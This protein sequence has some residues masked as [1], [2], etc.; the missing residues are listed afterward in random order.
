MIFLLN[1]EDNPT[2]SNQIR[3]LSTPASPVV[4]ITD[5]QPC[6]TAG[7]G[8][9]PQWRL[10]VANVV[11]CREI[12]RF[13]NV[14][15]TKY[16]SV[17]LVSSNNQWKKH[18]HIHL[19]STCSSSHFPCRVVSSE[20]PAIRKKAFSLGPSTVHSSFCHCLLFDG[21]RSDVCIL[22]HLATAIC[23]I[24]S[25]EFLLKRPWKRFLSLPCIFAASTASSHLT[26]QFGSP[27]NGVLR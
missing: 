10:C 1:H 5:L 15:G 23:P 14:Q 22:V 8:A 2:S 24:K 16:H 20:A 13:W 6:K 18:R 25:H 11:R 17:H 4:H 27:V 9:I 19:G 7:V 26:T 3:E 21:G 12:D